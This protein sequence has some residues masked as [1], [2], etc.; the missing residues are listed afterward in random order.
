MRMSVRVPACMRCVY[1]YAACT[2]AH[3][4]TNAY[5]FTLALKNL[6]IR[7]PCAPNT[8][9]HTQTHTIRPCAH[10]HMQR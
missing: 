7:I 2:R 8:Q 5:V 4:F 1:A 10:T 9:T 3:T 6:H